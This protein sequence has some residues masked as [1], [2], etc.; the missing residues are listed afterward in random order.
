ML[1]AEAIDDFA[2]R[3]CHASPSIIVFFA[4]ADAWLLFAMPSA[5]T[6]LIR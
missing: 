2:F 6:L 3:Y 5:D 1:L 4:D